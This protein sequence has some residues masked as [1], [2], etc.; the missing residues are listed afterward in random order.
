MTFM[1]N[2]M[3]TYNNAKLLM[4]NDSNISNDN[5]YDDYNDSNN[6]YYPWG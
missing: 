4:I 5:D 6:K 2:Y 1:S 3:N